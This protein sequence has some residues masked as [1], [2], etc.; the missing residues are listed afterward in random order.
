MKKPRTKAALTPVDIIAKIGKWS[1][2]IFFL[3][4]TIIP[5][6]W[7][8]LSSFKTNF[9]FE[10]QPFALPAV[11][12][13]QN[14]INAFNMA[15]LGRLFMNS[16]VV[17]VATTILNTIIAS[18]G[19]FAIAREK[20]KGNETILNILLSG[21]LI[22]II[23]LMVPYFKIVSNLGVYDSL[24]GLVLTY[25]A[26]N[27]PISVFLIHGFMGS[28]PKELEE[29][30]VIDGCSFA[31]RFSKIVFPLT[32][33]GLVTAGTFVFI[34]CWNEFIYAMRLTSSESSRNLQI[35]IRY[36]RSQF[37]TDYTGMLAAIVITMIPTILVYVFLHDRIIS[38]MTSGAVKG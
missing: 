38:G 29:A 24:A 15:G 18:M 34:Y 36:F 32:K 17:A 3:F 10:T 12:Q 28:I 30:A 27:I 16:I 1:Y 23:A 33:P 8:V 21:V 37:I 31:Q 35:G 25:S 26:I 13:I 9:E 2:I 22:P 14:Y 20:F 19:A 7:L 11:W 5:L 6:I 4:M